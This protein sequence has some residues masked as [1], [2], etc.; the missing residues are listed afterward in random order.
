[1]KCTI[2]AIAVPDPFN[3]NVGRAAIKCTTHNWELNSSAMAHANSQCPI[4]RIEDARD[5]ACGMIRNYAETLLKG[6]SLDG[7][8]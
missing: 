2:L 6:G 8:S 5:E 3:P 4:G 1:M 7:N